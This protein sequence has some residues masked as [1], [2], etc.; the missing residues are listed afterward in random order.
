[1]SC[2]QNDNYYIESGQMEWNCFRVG[3]N[4]LAVIDKQRK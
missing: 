4:S 3:R 2:F 1:M